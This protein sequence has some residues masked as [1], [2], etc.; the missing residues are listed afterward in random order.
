MRLL[1]REMAFTSQI[2]L[3]RCGVN[4]AAIAKLDATFCPTY[5]EEDMTSL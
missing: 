1:L 4:R 2:K 5:E 3:M